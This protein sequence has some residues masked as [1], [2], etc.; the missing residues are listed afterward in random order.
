MNL[1][2]A[3]KRVLNLSRVGASV[4]RRHRLAARGHSC[5]LV[6]FHVQAD[7][8]SHGW[9]LVTN[10]WLIYDENCCTNVAEQPPDLRTDRRSPGPNHPQSTVEPAADVL[11]PNFAFLRNVQSKDR[12]D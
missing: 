8:G 2:P 4:R 3:M 7:S 1:E 9:Y 10:K 12:L 5:S 6:C 11:H